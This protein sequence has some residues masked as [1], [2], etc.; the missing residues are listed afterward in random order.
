MTRGCKLH[1]SS[2][3]T[4]R[5]QDYFTYVIKTQNNENAKHSRK[6]LKGTGVGVGWAGREGEIIAE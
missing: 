3:P 4:A 5:H 2:V 1:W 6:T